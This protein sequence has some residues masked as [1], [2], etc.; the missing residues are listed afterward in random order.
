MVVVMMMMTKMMTGKTNRFC[1]VVKKIY[2]HSGIL[3]N[4]NLK[5]YYSRIPLTQHTR[6]EMGARLF[7]IKDYWTVP[8]L[9]YISTGTFLLLLPF[10]G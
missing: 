8:I 7:D 10:L 9:T 3:L 4:C 6:G 2:V 5:S 1:M